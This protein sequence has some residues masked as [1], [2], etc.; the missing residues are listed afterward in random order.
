MHTGVD[1]APG[2]DGAGIHT[3]GVVRKGK[4]IEGRDGTIGE[5]D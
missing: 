4:E 5:C 1:G 2:M 3:L